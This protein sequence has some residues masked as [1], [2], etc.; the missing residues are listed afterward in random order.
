MAL[1]AYDMICCTLPSLEEFVAEMT[2]KISVMEV[3]NYKTICVNIF[4]AFLMRSCGMQ[5]DREQFWLSLKEVSD[6]VHSRS[7]LED[8]I[9]CHLD[10]D[11]RLLHGR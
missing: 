4:V 11:L 9:C 5:G 1:Q 8:A 10:R 3:T 6:S 2:R 7:L